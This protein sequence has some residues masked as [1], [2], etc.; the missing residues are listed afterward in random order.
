MSKDYVF[1]V[2]KQVVTIQAGDVPLTYADDSALG[3][4]I[5]FM[6]KITLREGLMKYAEQYNTLYQIYDE[7]A[8]EYTK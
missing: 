6:P 5:G 2:H 1:D 8:M 3:R 7:Q 4:D